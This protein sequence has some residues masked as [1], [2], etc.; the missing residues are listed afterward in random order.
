MSSEESQLQDLRK[1]CVSFIDESTERMGISK[2]SRGGEISPYIV[3]KLLKDD[4]AEIAH[5]ALCHLS[6]LVASITG[7]EGVPHCM[8]N[9]LIETQQTVTNLQS[10]LL[11]YKDNELEALKSTVKSAVRVLY[12]QNSVH[13]V[14]SC[15]PA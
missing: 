10:E 5:N 11:A 15:K 7:H 2:L 13:T 12:N 9:E 3:K 14:Q 8:K 4:L 1:R 6:D